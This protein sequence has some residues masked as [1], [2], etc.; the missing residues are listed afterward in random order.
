MD[1]MLLRRAASLRVSDDSAMPLQRLPWG[2]AVYS[3]HSCQHSDALSVMEQGALT[4]LS[5]SV[6]LCQKSEP[7]Q[8]SGAHGLDCSLLLIVMRLMEVKGQLTRCT[9]S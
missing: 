4:E 7:G 5:A 9:A 3:P 2:L 8:W 6:S 1:S